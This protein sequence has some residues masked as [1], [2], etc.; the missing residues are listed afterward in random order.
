[1]LV[2]F[3]NHC[4]KT[5]SPTWDLLTGHRRLW[6]DMR[7]LLDSFVLI[8]WVLLA[9]AWFVLSASW[10]LSSAKLFEV[11]PEYLPVSFQRHP[12]DYCGTH[13]ET[14]FEAHLF[15]LHHGPKP[16]TIKEVWY[17]PCIRQCLSRTGPPLPCVDDC[18]KDGV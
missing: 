15:L 18:V 8:L 11:C 10:G 9:A 6:S 13:L 3:L 2:C 5:P 17:A 14:H 4:T 16:E 1:M 12:R 7:F